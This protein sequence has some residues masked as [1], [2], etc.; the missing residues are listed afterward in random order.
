MDLLGGAGGAHP[1]QNFLSTPP[2]IIAPPQK[3]FS[4]PLLSE[5]LLLSALYQF[6][7]LKVNKDCASKP[8]CKYDFLSLDPSTKQWFELWLLFL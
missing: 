8:Q 6:W 2:K 5:N 1:P 4:T 7:T 3:L